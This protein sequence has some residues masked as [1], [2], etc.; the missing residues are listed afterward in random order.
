M[1]PS[2]RQ[3][4][5]LPGVS[6]KPEEVCTHV[7]GPKQAAAAGRQVTAVRLGSVCTGLAIAR[8]AV[9]LPGGLISDSGEQLR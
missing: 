8:L 3:G 5:G 7:R 4:K 1:L 6:S 2:G 9:L